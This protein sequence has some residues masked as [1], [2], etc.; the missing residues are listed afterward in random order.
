MNNV[1][2]YYPHVQVKLDY[3]NVY[4]KVL[5]LMKKICRNVWKNGFLKKKILKKCL[6]WKAVW[7]TIKTL[8]KFY[9]ISSAKLSFNNSLLLIYLC[10]SWCLKHTNKVLVW[11]KRWKLVL[12]LWR[13]KFLLHTCMRK[14]IHFKKCLRIWRHQ[15]LKISI[16]EN[17][18]YIQ[19][20]R[21]EQQPVDWNI[22]IRHIEC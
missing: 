8:S 5:T 9:G 3:R 10:S 2:Y 16:K 11:A 21:N 17:S 4:M 18:S 12:L 22:F 20:A 7:K 6:F 14:Y 13:N 19:I 15:R 1:F